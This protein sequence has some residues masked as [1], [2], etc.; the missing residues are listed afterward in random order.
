MGTW[1]LIRLLMSHA[2]GLLSIPWLGVFLYSRSAKK[3]SVLAFLDFFIFA[4]LT[5]ASTFPLL[6]CQR[7]CHVSETPI[8]TELLKFIWNKLRAIVWHT[9]FW[10]TMPSKLG[11]QI[12]DHCCWP[13]V[14]KKIY[15]PIIGIVIHTDEVVMTPVTEQIN[16]NFAPRPFR[17]F[18]WDQRLFRL[19]LVI[20]SANITRL[21]ELL[22]L[23]THARPVDAFS[24]SWKAADNTRMRI[25]KMPH[26]VLTE[27][28]WKYLSLSLDN[29]AIINTQFVTYSKVQ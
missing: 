6:W 14:L 8:T 5:T 21:N 25:M 23:T 18:M 20:D 9:H 2:T 3:G 16:S 26:Q 1:V 7:G 15:L 12:P 11:L 29:H 13:C 27:Q 22:D 10:N 19:S 24:C 4:D 28:F 17:N